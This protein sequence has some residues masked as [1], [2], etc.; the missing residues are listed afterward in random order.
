MKS[1]VEKLDAAKLV[2]VTVDLSRLS[3]VVKNDLVKKTDYNELVKNVNSIQTTDTSNS[4]QKADYDTQIS[5]IEKKITDHNMYITTKFCCKIKRR[6]FSN[7][8]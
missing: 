3:D 1:K 2:P 5:E 4:T 8:S 7:G 6:K